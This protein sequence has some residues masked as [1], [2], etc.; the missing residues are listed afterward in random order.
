MLHFIMA[1]TFKHIEGANYIALDINFWVIDRITDTGLSCKMDDTL[2]T[3][4]SKYSIYCLLV[5]QIIL[6][7]G[8]SFKL[9][10]NF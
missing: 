2:G 4:F 7:E 5:F 10:K 9:L 8:E 1:A 6:V 3:I